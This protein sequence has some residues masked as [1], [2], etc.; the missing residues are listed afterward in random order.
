[1]KIAVWHNLNS[2]G[3][4]RALY[5]HVKGLLERGHQIEAW[6][7]DSIDQDYLPLNKLIKEHIIPIKTNN[8]L[9]NRAR[10][11]IL[12]PISRINERISN[13]KQHCLECAEQ[14]NNG[15]FDILLANS[16]SDFHMSFVG[17]YI[18]IP[19]IIY[20]QEP[21]RRLY[22]ALPT[23]P[24]IAPDINSMGLFHPIDTLREISRLL[25][26]S[27][28]TYALRI[29]VREEL[30]AAKSYNRI[31]VNSYFS[32]ESVLRAYGLNSWV[33]Y[34]GVDQNLFHQGNRLKQNYVVGMG[35][36]QHTKGIDRAIKAV[37]AIPKNKRPKFIWIANRSSEDYEDEMRK[38]AASLQVDLNFRIRIPDHELQDLL[39][40]AAVMLYTPRLEPFGLAPL[41]ANACC[42]AVIGIAE[43]GIR[44][45]I[46]TGENGTL[47]NNENPQEFEK[48]ILSFTENLD[49]A[50]EFGIKACKHV[51]KIWGAERAIG[52]LEKYLKE[53]V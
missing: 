34:L 52:R 45:T 33:C 12:G 50:T 32:R 28:N 13:I 44:E 21:Y 15:G 18:K 9:F 48:A 49:Y 42:T 3:A 20:F 16:S 26:E 30:K 36:V 43:G 11:R 10:R 7:P 39:S 38:L 22:E 5:H 2:G 25:K 17:L 23:L 47:I 51:R 19:N 35:G 37:A 8:H 31:L 24:W 6:C 46:Q 27:M 41:E 53:T 4:K 29:Q 1:L 14:I 40:C